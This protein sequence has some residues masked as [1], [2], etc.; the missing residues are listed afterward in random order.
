MKDK[1]RLH[2]RI[3]T[4]ERIVY[5]DDVDSVTLPTKSGEITILV[6]HVPLVSVLNS[7]ELMIK[8]DEKEIF[9]AVSGGFIETDGKTLTVLADMA[10]RAEEI[11]EKKADEARA[12]AEELMLAR[13]GD[14][15]GYADAMAHMERELARLKVAR[16]FRKRSG[17]GPSP[18]SHE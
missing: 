13:K 3:N 7:G 16:K 8:K 12:K 10:E 15:V 2:L 17:Q 5:E 1:Q 6:N 9:I 4:M 11:D 14:D 18:I